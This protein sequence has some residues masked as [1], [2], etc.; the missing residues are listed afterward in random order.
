MSELIEG[1]GA[2]SAAILNTACLLPLYPGL[3]AF[4]AGNAKDERYRR[5]TGWMGLLVLAGVLSMMVIVALLVHLLHR[6][7]DQVF[8]VLLPLVY[9]L[10]IGFGVLMLADRSPFT[11]LATVQAP[12]TRN[13]FATAFVYGLLIG[14]IALPCIGPFLTA[15]FALGARDAGSLAGS[16]AYFLGFGL[17]FGWPLL[18]LPLIALPAQRRLVGR[19]ARH[20]RLLNR[21]SGVLLVAIGLFGIATELLP[22]WN[23]DLGI[24]PESWWVYWGLAL[25]AVVAVGAYT[26]R[27]QKAAPT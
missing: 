27:Q 16:M 8:P 17:G 21:V 11:R 12:V 15:S 14:P 4:L 26:V 7:F 24:P 1:F 22:R 9:G 25:L 23:P 6:S 13:P 18:I 10:V 20:H 5:R 3:I 19:V 2:G